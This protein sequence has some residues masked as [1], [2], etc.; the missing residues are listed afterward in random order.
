MLF[1]VL[2]FENWLKWLSLSSSLSNAMIQ[3]TQQINLQ[4]ETLA[5]PQTQLRSW[6]K[7]QNIE[8]SDPI[9]KLN[10]WKSFC[11]MKINSYSWFQSKILNSLF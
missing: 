6:Y 9:D 4:T 10:L 8:K 3:A 1:C 11:L 5:V 2:I 7:N